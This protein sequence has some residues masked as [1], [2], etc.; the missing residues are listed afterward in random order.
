MTSTPR[1]SGASAHGGSS[2]ERVTRCEP[3]AGDGSC[4]QVVLVSREHRSR[5]LLSTALELVNAR[6]RVCESLEAALFEFEHAL[7]APFDMLVLDDPLHC[8]CDARSRARLEQRRAEGW[9]IPV[10]VVLSS[11]DVERM[12]AQ[13]EALADDWLQR[14]V[15]PHGLALRMRSALRRRAEWAR[16][17]PRL[18]FHDLSLDLD[19]LRARGARGEIECSMRELQ[20]LLALVRAGGAAVHRTELADRLWGRGAA[21]ARDAMDRMVAR[22]RS[23]LRGKSGVQIATLPKVGWRLALPGWRQRSGPSKHDEL[24]RF[25]S[26]LVSASNQAAGGVRGEPADAAHSNEWAVGRSRV[27]TGHRVPGETPTGS[28][29]P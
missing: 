12:G 27:R 16:G 19:R 1:R 14:P 9:S 10:L 11:E 20:V 23:R 22:L 26:S 5:A 29:P 21:D 28:L 6:T 2:S 15:E 7:E 13:M 18:S 17:N 4:L 8:D 3:S 24:V 25:P